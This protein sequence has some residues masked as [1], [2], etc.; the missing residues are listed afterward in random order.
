[1]KGQNMAN[2]KYLRKRIAL[3]AAAALGV[4]LLVAAP[5]S[6]A[7]ATLAN[8]YF[9]TASTHTTT[10]NVAVGSATSVALTSAWTGAA[11]SDT[12]I[13][14]PT[15]TSKPITSSAATNATYL[16]YTVSAG[17]NVAA[18]TPFGQVVTGGTGVVTS[19]AATAA[20]AVVSPAINFTPDVAGIYVLTYIMTSAVG[21]T[22]D[23][24]AGSSLT[25]VLTIVAG[26]TVDTTN[27]NRALA[28]QGSNVTTSLN[29]SS[30]HVL[31]TS[32]PLIRTSTTT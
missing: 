6:A 11:T 17:T 14:T 31:R 12:S 1:L 3:V 8:A 20:A 18:T 28:V 21:I 15:L 26:T 32:I 13:L 9:G 29:L 19:T 16:N 10:V 7:N 23:G 22:V 30:G 2:A 5:A 27:V 25:N 4:G 24:T